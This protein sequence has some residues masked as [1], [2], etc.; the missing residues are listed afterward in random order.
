MPKFVFITPQEYFH[1][2]VNATIKILVANTISAKMFFPQRHRLIYLQIK[3][4]LSLILVHKIY[5]RG[6]Y[7]TYY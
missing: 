3:V 5:Q 2:Q 7:S 1:S 6:M 4:W